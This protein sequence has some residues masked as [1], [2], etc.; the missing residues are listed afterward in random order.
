MKRSLATLVLATVALAAPA[1]AQ[2]TGQDKEDP[3]QIT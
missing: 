2:D 3:H 1:Y